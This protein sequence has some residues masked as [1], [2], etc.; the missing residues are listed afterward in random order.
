MDGAGTHADIAQFAHWV[1]VVTFYEL[2]GHR[3]NEHIVFYDTIHKLLYS[4]E[5]RTGCGA[6]LR[7]GSNAIAAMECAKSFYS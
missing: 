2:R 6:T 5:P 7:L 4:T 1:Q 3:M